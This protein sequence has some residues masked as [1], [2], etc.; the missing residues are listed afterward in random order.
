MA[1]FDLEVMVTGICAFVPDSNGKR[2]CVVLPDCTAIDN[3]KSTIDKKTRL[4]THFGLV[5]LAARHAAP[6]LADLDAEYVWHLRRQRLTLELSADDRAAN[7]PET[8]GLDDV[9]AIEKAI[10]DPSPDPAIVGAVPPRSVLAHYVIDAGR[11]EPDMISQRVWKA[12]P[13]VKSPEYKQKFAHGVAVRLSR[14]SG[15]TLVA[16][17]LDPAGAVQRLPLHPGRPGEKVRVYVTNI[18][19]DNPLEWERGEEAPRPDVDVAWYYELLS[20]GAKKRLE[21]DLASL[22]VPDPERTVPIL[23]VHSLGAGGSNCTPAFFPPLELGF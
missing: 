12:S 7:P 11:V 13:A 18:C 2:H 6:S 23:Q 8:N 3:G 22:P 15:A 10:N 14:I 21:T 1:T 20:A 4:G 16:T 9:L 17:P 5:H 19:Y